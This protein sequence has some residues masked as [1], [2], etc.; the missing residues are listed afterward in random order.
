MA[1]APDALDA[2]APTNRPLE[3]LA[4]SAAHRLLRSALAPAAI[5][6]AICLPSANATLAANGWQAISTVH[7]GGPHGNEYLRG[8]AVNATGRAWAVGEFFDG[9][10]RSHSLLIQ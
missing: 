6:L 2:H 9:S 5:C 3:D 10:S 7:P 8:V 4:M 1:I